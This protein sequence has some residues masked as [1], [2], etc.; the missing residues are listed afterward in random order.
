[1]SLEVSGARGLG[2][3]PQTVAAARLRP[4]A[5]LSLEGVTQPDSSRS[6]RADLWRFTDARSTERVCVPTKESAVGFRL[7]DEIGGLLRGRSFLA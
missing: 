1:M 6:H 5:P 3:D 2:G 4:L 7:S